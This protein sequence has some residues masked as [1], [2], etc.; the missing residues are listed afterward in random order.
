MKNVK[1]YNSGFTIIELLFALTIFS[2]L[3]IAVSSLLMT[4][5]KISETSKQQ[6][7]ALILAQNHLEMIKASKEV[8]KAKERYQYGIYDIEVDIQDIPEYGGKLYKVIIEV[9]AYNRILEKIEG[10]KIVE[11]W[12]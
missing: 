11:V 5:I 10:L 6:Y 7:D 2:I 12:E 3:F 1:T 4:T 8:L 9:S